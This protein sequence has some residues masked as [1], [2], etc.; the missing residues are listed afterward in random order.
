MKKFTAFILSLVVAVG[1][2]FFIP[3]GMTA[4]AEV[5]KYFGKKSYSLLEG[6]KGRNGI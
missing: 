3:D 2:C 1:S 4:Y 6:V 5:R